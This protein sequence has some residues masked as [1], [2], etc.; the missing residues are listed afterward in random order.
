MELGD[1]VRGRQVEEVGIALDVPRV[2][3][4][5]LA[6]V[7]LLRELLP[8]DEHPPRPV[9]HEYSLRREAAGVVVRTSFTKSAPA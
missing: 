8:V 1:D 6:A 2:L 3:P 4:E 5:P 9:E 7:L